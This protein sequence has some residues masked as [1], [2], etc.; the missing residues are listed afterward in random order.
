MTRDVSATSAR[1]TR[2]RTVAEAVRQARLAISNSPSSAVAFASNA[3]SV[4][5]AG[6]VGKPTT[7]AGF[8]VATPLTVPDGGTGLA[9]FAIG[10][11]LYATAATTLST[12]AIGSANKVLTSSGTAPQWSNSLA[13]LTAVSATT[14]TGALVGNANR[15]DQLGR[16]T[17]AAQP[18]I[19]SVGTLTG[20][21]VKGTVAITGASSG[22]VS[23]VAQAAAGSVTYVLPNAD[24]SNN[25][26]LTTDGSGN[27]SWSVKTGGAGG[28]ISTINGDGS[29]AQTI[30]AGAGL[31]IGNAGAVH[32]LAL[33]LNYA[34]TYTITTITAA[35]FAGA[36]GG[37]M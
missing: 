8:G 12:L 14:F 33:D 27:L 10:D 19:T 34:P 2:D 21:T 28:T 31:T 9:T 36:V 4:P 13:G 7:L 11:M 32:T 15:D 29:A 6:I 23:F 17:T 20:L 26:V 3:G 1:V 18:A 16:L 37:V 30:A 25:F 24:G 35:G 22:S 5:W